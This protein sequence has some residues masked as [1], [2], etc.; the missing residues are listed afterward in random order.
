M[1]EYKNG[2]SALGNVPVSPDRRSSDLQTGRA[3]YVD[4]ADYSADAKYKDKVDTVEYEGYHREAPIVVPE[5]GSSGGSGSLK[6]ANVTF[7]MQPYTGTQA[8]SQITY[9][10]IENGVLVLKFFELGSGTSVTVPVAI[11]DAG[12][13]YTALYLSTAACGVESVE[14]SATVTENEHDDKDVL[15]TGDC[16]ITLRKFGLA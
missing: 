14:G 10:T 3:V 15:I 6:T 16:T 4:E 2:F 7:V 11:N 12:F 9:P 13:Q 8:V 1:A 5:K